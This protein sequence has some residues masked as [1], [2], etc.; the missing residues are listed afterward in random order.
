MLVLMA[1]QLSPDGRQ[2]WDGSR[3]L[4]ISDDGRWRWDGSRWLAVGEG[5]IDLLVCFDTTGSMDD[6]IPGLIAQTANFVQA[7]SASHFNLRWGLIA[8][9]DLRVDGDKIV[10]YPFTTSTP[11]FVGA[12]RRMP[13]FLGGGNSGETSLDALYAAAQHRGWTSTSVRMTVLITDEPPVGLDVDLEMVGQAMR[14]QRIVVFCVGPEHR[15][16]R[17]LAK[18][19]G[20]DF[21]DIY[22]R[23]PFERI[24][25]RLAKRMVKVAEQIR[26]LLSAGPP[27]PA[28]KG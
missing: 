15:A 21:W 9:G 1:L 4:P 10:Q 2:W 25:E 6:K 12:L 24:L 23:V 7:A 28:L 17:W 5:G 22:E 27:P 20:G 8:F 11:E 14:E 16:Y 18:V 26:P 19:T 3:W 13:S